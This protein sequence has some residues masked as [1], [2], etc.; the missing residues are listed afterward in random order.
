MYTNTR[1]MLSSRP[2]L[3][4][5]FKTTISTCVIKHER[6]YLVLISENDKLIKSTVTEA[7]ILYIRHFNKTSSNLWQWW[8]GSQKIGI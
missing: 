6:Q 3:Q 8:L 5:C 1:A 7:E 4:T 2:N